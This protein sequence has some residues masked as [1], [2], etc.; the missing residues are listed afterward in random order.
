MLDWDDFMPAVGE[1]SG[2]DVRTCPELWRPYRDLLRTVT[3]TL[4][5]VPAVLFTVCTPNELADWPDAYWIS[6]TATTRSAVDAFEA[7]P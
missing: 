7:A 2:R 3:A 6:S 1:L 4:S 5:G